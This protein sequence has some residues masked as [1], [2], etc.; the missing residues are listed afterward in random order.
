MPSMTATSTLSER[1]FVALVEALSSDPT[2]RAELTDLLR[3]DHPVYDQRSAGAIVRMRGW[4]LVALTHVGLT[5]ATLLFVLEELD[6]GRDAYL[7]AAAAR[8][9]RSYPKPVAAFAPFVM[10][11][12]AN[13]RNNNSTV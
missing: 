11:A 12:I 1:Q 5:D 3:E 2:R 7:V 6:T 8:A 4:I 9:L 10:R 13:I